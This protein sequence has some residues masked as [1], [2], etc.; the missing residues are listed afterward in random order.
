MFIIAFFCYGKSSAIFALFID[1]SHVPRM[2]GIQLVLIKCEMIAIV[3]FRLLEPLFMTNI[4]SQKHTHL[5]E[6][7]INRPSEEVEY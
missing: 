4:T 6:S 2:L 1:V 7:R 5:I 3:Y